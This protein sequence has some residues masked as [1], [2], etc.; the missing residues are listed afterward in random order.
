[1]TMRTPLLTFLTFVVVFD[2]LGW[3]LGVLPTLY[4]AFTRGHLPTLAGI[5][6]LSGPIERLGLAN[7]I[8]AGLLF[9]VVSALKLLAAYWLSQARRDGAVLELILLALSALFWYGFALP[10]GPPVGLIQLVLLALT[11]TALR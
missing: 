7:L 3:I 9:V 4:Y 5:R 10:F 11:W 1:M 6:L 2:A 8:V